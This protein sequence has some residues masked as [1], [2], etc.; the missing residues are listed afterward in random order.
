M[1]INVRRAFPALSKKTLLTRRSVPERA[2]RRGIKT[3]TTRRGVILAQHPN[4]C[5]LLGGSPGYSME[6][7]DYKSFAKK[8]VARRYQDDPEPGTELV[9]SVVVLE[10]LKKPDPGLC[11][12]GQPTAPEQRLQS[13]RVSQASIEQA[14][15]GHPALAWPPVR[16]GKTT[17]L[18]TMYISVD[19]QERV[20]EPYPLNSDNAGL[21]EAARDQFLN[22]KLKPM[23]VKNVPLQAE[24]ALTFRFATTLAVPPP[25]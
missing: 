5:F 3:R 4:S 23:V 6:F 21:Q 13:L 19:R 14:A 17:G 1:R 15:D 7:H 16:S 24:A 10:E 18:L 2:V 12:I 22:W 8:M 9:A 20:R 11:S 25:K